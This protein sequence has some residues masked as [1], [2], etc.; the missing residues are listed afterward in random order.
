LFFSIGGV[1]KKQLGKQ[2]SF[3]AGLQ[4]NYYSNTIDVGT[5]VVQSARFM[6][7][8][9]TSFYSNRVIAPTSTLHPYRN[10][11]HFVSLPL[12]IEWQLF[13]KLPLDFYIW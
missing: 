2:A 5:R 3:S 4:Y 1:A 10:N 9:V 12:T 11:Y 8:S 6:D 7:Y 13:K